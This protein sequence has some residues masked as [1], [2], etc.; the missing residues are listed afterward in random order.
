MQASV[1]SVCA[2]SADQMTV[3]LGGTGGGVTGISLLFHSEDGSCKL[4]GMWEHP[5]PP[6]ASLPCLSVFTK[7]VYCGQHL[8][9]SVYHL[10]H[11]EL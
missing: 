6:S 1:S 9:A 4:Q 2:Y 10:L 5:S 8:P 7:L 3:T 11:S